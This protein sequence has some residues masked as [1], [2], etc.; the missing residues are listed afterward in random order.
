MQKAYYQATF[1][2]F[3]CA[4]ASFILGELVRAHGFAL[5]HQQRQAWIEQ[6][7]LLK[8]AAPRSG[9]AHVLLEFAI[10]R[11]GKRAD[12]IIVLANAIL[13]LEFKVG[14]SS[15]DASHIEQVY[16]YA[17]DLKNFHVGSHNAPIVPILYSTSA[18][19]QSGFDLSWGHDRVAKPIS[20]GT[21]QLGKVLGNIA[22]VN[23]GGYINYEV[24]LASGYRPTP[25]IVEAAQALFQQHNVEAITRSDAGAQNLGATTKVL[26]RIIERS[27]VAGEKSIC[28]VTGVPGAG[29]TLAGLN[30]ATMRA[31]SHEDEHA[32]FLSGNGPLVDVLRE[33][34]ARDESARHGISKS[35]ALRRVRSFIQNIHHFRD[36]ALLDSSAPVERVVVFDEAQ[37][38]WTKDQAAKFMKAKR[39]V[40]DF[41]MSEPEF[42]IRVM[43]RHEDWCVVI[44]LIGE[45]QEINT[46]E[47]G[48]AEWLTALSHSFKTWRVYASDRTGDSD[49]VSGVSFPEMKPSLEADLHLAVSIR[50][51]RAESLSDFVDHLVTNKPKMALGSY[52]NISDRYPIKITRDINL[53]RSW[54][55]SQARGSERYGLVASSGAL[56]L[57]PEG[58]HIRAQIDPPVWFLNGKSDVRSSFYCEEVA[59]EF[60]VQGLELDW[61]GVCWDADFRYV[62]GQ[63]DS[64]DFKGTR[65][66]RV[67]SA[68][69]QEFL[70]NA[71]RV[72]LT[73][74]RQGMVIFV[75]KGDPSD[76]TRPPEF[77][78]ETF[79]F[80][81]L[82][83]LDTL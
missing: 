24:W 27:K 65:W 37:R 73:R 62:A 7:E 41:S 59:S 42:L 17:L 72:I 12:A 11:M 16:D 47:A 31:R 79:K 4:D 18:P 69:A 81:Q 55:R 71:Y 44:C 40:T 1:E 53:A 74:A 82:C 63:W 2:E 52:A 29:K 13:V 57:R 30:I 36:S 21:G 46:G 6:I 38:A 22:S 14:A 64:F 3:R 54:L 20:I 70:R 19:G 15:F 67:R 66:Q 33:A 78:D 28:F 25:T 48:F 83:G 77:Y 49:A 39:G 32:V 76:V 23:T 50:S 10:P 8:S 58:I 56:R 60:D 9:D 80:L 5:E 26:E 61:T 34:L 35:E 45:G 51:F 68:E 43:D 75:P